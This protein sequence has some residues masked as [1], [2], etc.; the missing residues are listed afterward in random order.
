MERRETDEPLCR[1]ETAGAVGAPCYEIRSGVTLKLVH[2]LPL[3]ATE[4]LLLL[5]WAAAK[6][7]STTM[8]R[9]L[10]RGAAAGHWGIALLGIGLM[11][12]GEQLN[13]RSIRNLELPAWAAAL[14]VFSSLA[15]SGA[16]VAAAAG[17]YAAQSDCSHQE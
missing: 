14:A 5:S 8:A 10:T 11:L 7:R 6:S 15:I 1:D 2:F 4:S 12:T 16:F 9:Y 13:P 17:R 3:H